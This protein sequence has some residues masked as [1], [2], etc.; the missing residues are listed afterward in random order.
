MITT[1]SL[2]ILLFTTRKQNIATDEFSTSVVKNG[3]PRET[4]SLIKYL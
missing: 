2:S 3:N 1:I 4:L